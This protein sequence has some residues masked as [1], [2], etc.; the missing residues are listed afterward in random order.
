M[1]KKI[2]QIEYARGNDGSYRLFALAEDSSVFFKFVGHDETGEEEISREWVIFAE[3]TASTTPA[4]GDHGLRDSLAINSALMTISEAKRELI[5]L[6]RMDTTMQETE[7]VIKGAIKITDDGMDRIS[8]L[9]GG[10]A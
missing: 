9:V 5:I 1:N 2:K 6:S 10:R 4:I 7:T 8:R 3:P